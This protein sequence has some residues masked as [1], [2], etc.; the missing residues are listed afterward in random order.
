MGE[1]ALLAAG[2][3]EYRGDEGG[4]GATEETAVG[5]EAVA[6]LLRTFLGDEVVCSFSQGHCYASAKIA[7]RD[8]VWP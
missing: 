8:A 2:G 1:G 5:G 3:A 6:L 7:C 4:T